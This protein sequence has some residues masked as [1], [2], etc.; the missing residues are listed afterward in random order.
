MARAVQ[1]K[2][3]DHVAF[4][5]ADRDPIEAAERIIADMPNRPEIQYSGSKAFY[6]SITDRITLPPRELFESVEEFYAT[7]DHELI[8]ACGSPKRL[9]A[10]TVKRSESRQTA[11][12]RR[13]TPSS[14]NAISGCM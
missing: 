2:T 8:H 9:R 12:S 1:P 7:L 11:P 3:L 4:W 10:I 13:S 6:S 5:V 14:S